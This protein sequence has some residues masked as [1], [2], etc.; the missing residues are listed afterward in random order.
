MN[1]NNYDNLPRH[2]KK[3]IQK[4]GWTEAEI[5]EWLVKPVPALGNRNIVQALADGSLQEVN[6]VVLRVGDAMNITDY[7]E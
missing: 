7:F 2:L 1:K 6:K 5:N 4:F 3:Y